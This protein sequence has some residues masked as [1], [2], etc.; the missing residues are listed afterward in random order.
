[1]KDRI[2]EVLVIMIGLGAAYSTLKPLY[3]FTRPISRTPSVSVKRRAFTRPP[4]HRIPRNPNKK[5]DIKYKDASSTMDQ[6]LF[7]TIR[8]KSK[9]AGQIDESVLEQ[10]GKYY[11]AKRDA[12]LKE[13]TAGDYPKGRHPGGA[14]TTKQSGEFPGKNY[15]SKQSKDLRSQGSEKQSAVEDSYN[16]YPV[17]EF[18]A[19]YYSKKQ[20]DELRSSSSRRSEAVAYSSYLN[21]GYPAESY[22]GKLADDLSR[23]TVHTD[24]PSATLGGNYDP[25]SGSISDDYVVNKSGT[26]SSDVYRAKQDADLR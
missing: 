17:S 7:V 9:T 14:Y 24:D 11:N 25:N 2:I 26:T 10:P 18:T 19:M 4:S 12:D 5:L 23:L 1:M 15:S 21:S 6:S 13:R 22:N 16:P 8:E 3:E 20:A